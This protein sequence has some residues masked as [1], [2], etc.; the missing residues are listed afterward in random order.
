MSKSTLSKSLRRKLRPHGS[1]ES[2]HFR[3]PEKAAEGKSIGSATMKEDGTIVLQLR[4]EGPGAGA[5][6][7]LEQP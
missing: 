6:Y 3:E 5:N 2:S 7:R 1:W 4:A